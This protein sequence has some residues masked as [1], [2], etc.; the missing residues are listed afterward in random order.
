MA[1]VIVYKGNNKFSYTRD[2]IVAEYTDRPKTTDECNRIVLMLA[3]LY[4][5]EVMY[6]NEVPEVKSYFAH[7]KKLQY[8]AAQPDGVISKNIKNSRV[9]RVYGI[10][11]NAK[12]KDAGEKY[13]K[14]W[15][16][17]ERDIDEEGNVLL[18][19]DTICSIGLLEELIAY[20]RKG[21]FDRVMS[22]MTLMFALEEE[23][24]KEFKEDNEDNIAKD[25]LSFGK[26]LFK[27][28]NNLY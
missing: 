10:H 23:G 9:N 27:R 24:E 16:L 26:N 21:N 5:A 15:L 2:T 13:I 6:E 3:I 14:R 17:E 12:L 18:N 22:F 1:S 19:L 8:L 7:K 11:M 28:R 20:N 25:I 4:N